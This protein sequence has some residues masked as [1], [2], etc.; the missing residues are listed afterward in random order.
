MKQSLKTGTRIE[1]K[2]LP[3][4]G[5]FPG[6]APERGTICRWKKVNGEHVNRVREGGETGWHIVRLD[7]CNPLCMHENG[8]RVIDNR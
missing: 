3:A 4:M 7:G 6:V 1:T 2:G 5:G 8:F